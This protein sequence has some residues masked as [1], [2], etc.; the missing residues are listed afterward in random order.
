MM[1]V[2]V[3]ALGAPPDS[4]PPPP[5]LYPTPAPS[6]WLESR[7]PL[8]VALVA[9]AFA[10]LAIAAHVSPVSPVIAR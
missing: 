4:V 9:V 1:P 8:L 10:G 7:A 5:P 3:T 2:S 6:P